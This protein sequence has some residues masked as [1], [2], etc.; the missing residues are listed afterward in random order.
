MARPWCLYAPPGYGLYA[1]QHSR[2]KGKTA[3]TCGTVLTADTSGCTFTDMH[4]T[5]PE[6]AIKAE[7]I[8]MSLEE[9]AVLTGRSFSAVYRYKTGTRTPP[10][11][12]LA[13]VSALL[14]K[15]RLDG[16]RGGNAA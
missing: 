4:N 13:Q 15:A 12:W 1:C 6:W 9:I 11:E 2:R 8:G 5:T 16:E 14:A 10:P 7:R 3:D